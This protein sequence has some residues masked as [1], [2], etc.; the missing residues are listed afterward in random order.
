MH[1]Y[2]WNPGI[3]EVEG[4][5][6][7]FYKEG[8][9]ICINTVNKG[10]SSHIRLL[11]EHIILGFFSGAGKTTLLC[12]LCGHSLEDIQPTSGFEIKACQFKH[13]ILNVK[14]IGG[15]C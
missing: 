4:R 10:L 2:F 15:M 11:T 3:T 9:L 6:G 1:L 13:C 14:E 7:A 5:V 12:Q 8:A